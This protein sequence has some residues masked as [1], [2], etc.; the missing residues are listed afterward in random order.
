MRAGRGLPRWWRLLPLA[1][2]LLGAAG[3]VRC[4]QQP[5][6]KHDPVTLRIGLALP[7]TNEAGT[8]VKSF[9]GN[10]LSE[11][12]VGIGWD[13]RPVGRLASDWH[14]SSDGLLLTLKLS[15]NL[16]FHDGTVIDAAFVKPDLEQYL[17]KSTFS[18]KTLLGVNTVGTDQLTV[19]LSK[20]EAFLLADL[21]NFLL[22]HPKDPN[23]GLGPYQLLPGTPVRLGAF[24]KYDRGRPQ[25]DFIEVHEFEE[26]RSSW[27]ALMRGEIDAVHEISPA[28]RPF[29]EKQTS[30]ATFPFT[31]PY[32]ISLFFNTRHPILKSPTIRQ[33]L[34]YAVDR[35]G[36]I[37]LGLD[38]Q[39]IVAE[40]PIWPFHWAYSTAPKTYTRNL[41]A[42]TLRLESAG[43]RKKASAQPG[44]MPSRFRFRCLTLPRYEKMALVLQKQLSEVGVDF[45]IQILP[46]TELVARMR[47][48]DF[49][50]V[51]MERT[52]GRSLAW[53]YFF[54]YSKA[55]SL[56]YS[57]ADKSL[58]RLRTATADSETRDAVSEFQQVVY[59]DPPAI[60]IAWPQ[61]ARVV[62][63]R[64]AVSAE[65]KGRDV[66]S[67]LPQW[68]VAT[69]GR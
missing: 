37:K 4:A 15:K 49:D 32:F 27:A 47:S 58:D 33:A 61:V 6:A 18:Y 38:G 5:S 53:T 36:L 8:G 19:S 17:K 22:S 39:G 57:G 24:D 41:E 65:E 1:L 26:Q 2:A 34:S 13:G 25:I 42:A 12:L 11:Q 60:F 59:D 23:I 31:R 66:I 69:P 55:M 48:G 3:T 43:L 63:T 30:V 46:G 51:L 44:Q 16:Q 67:T 64:F 10:L 68:K 14:W 62:S 45:E 9:V 20:P 29:I 7:K 50:S 56:G 54:F 52:S 21:A 40:G 35:E 28:A